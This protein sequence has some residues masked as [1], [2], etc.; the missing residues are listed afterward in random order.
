MHGA[1]TNAHQQHK[2]TQRHKLARTTKQQPTMRNKH[3]YTNK[4]INNHQH[5]IRHIR[6]A[7]NNNK[8]RQTPHAQH[9]TTINTHI[10]TKTTNVKHLF[11]VCLLFCLCFFGARFKTCL[12]TFAVCSYAG[13][14][15]CVHCSINCFAI[16]IQCGAPVPFPS[17]GL[18]SVPLI[19]DSV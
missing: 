13:C 16:S 2:T 1:T 8:T 15:S 3:I 19:A 11:F 4:H 10:Y 14:H 5:H 17:R 12:L 6:N 18:L 9:N 7:S